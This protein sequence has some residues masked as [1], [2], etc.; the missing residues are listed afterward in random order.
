MSSSSLT[1]TWR[2]RG[3][4]KDD[5]GIATVE[6]SLVGVL[7]VVAIIA[8]MEIGRYALFMHSLNNAVYEAA[9]FA[10]VHGQSSE[11]PFSEQ[12]LI[13]IIEES[14]ATITNVV[15][16]IAISFSPDNVNKAGNLI[17]VN[18]N[19]PYTLAL[20]LLAVSDFYIDSSS[21]LTM[22]N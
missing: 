6:F 14:L 20:P 22:Q 19:L 21:A 13:D 2:N 18:A 1:E 7:I 17:I 11:A 9:R 5:G 3:G 10:I 4:L 8:I 15:P 16:Q 12:D